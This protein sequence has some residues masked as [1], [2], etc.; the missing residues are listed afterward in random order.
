MELFDLLDKD[1]NP[2]GRTH[3]RGEAIPKGAYHRVVDILT[4]NS[5]NQILVTL[6]DPNKENYPNLWEFTGGSVVAGESSVDGAVRELREE[7]GI[8]AL[9]QELK[10]F[11]TMTT[12][13]AVVDIYILRRDVE[14]SELTM[15]PGE[16]VDAKWVTV[17]EFE[18]MLGGDMLPAPVCVKYD[19]IKDDLYTELGI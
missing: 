1:G 17:A 4:V 18:N 3:V 2:I 10:L 8:I 15:Q 14:L 12:E 16:T 13:D 19:Q 9:P 7:T 5:Q 11:M 6:R